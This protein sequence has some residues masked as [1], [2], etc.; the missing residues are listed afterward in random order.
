MYSPN[1]SQ[2]HSTRHSFPTEGLLVRDLRVV[3]GFNPNI[4]VS[5][6]PWYS[7]WAQTCLPP[8]HRSSLVNSLVLITQHNTAETRAPF[9]YRINLPEPWT[10]GNKND[11]PAPRPQ[12]THSA[13]TAGTQDFSLREW[14]HVWRWP[15]PSTTCDFFPISQGQTERPMFKSCVVESGTTINSSHNKRINYYWF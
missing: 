11:S 3:H 8:L 9:S 13:L 4:L 7:S 5:D 15:T 10:S 12:S 2:G 1:K 6:T 14:V